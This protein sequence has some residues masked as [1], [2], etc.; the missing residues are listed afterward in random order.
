MSEIRTHFHKI[1]HGKVVHGK[2]AASIGD[3]VQAW[4]PVATE[5]FSPLCNDIAC[6]EAL[7]FALEQHINEIDYNCKYSKPH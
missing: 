6:V 3:H 2:A 4:V 1:N 5:A 7:E